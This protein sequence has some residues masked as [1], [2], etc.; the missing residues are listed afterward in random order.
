VPPP[1][2]PRPRDSSAPFFSVDA[3]LPGRLGRAGVIRTPH[4]DIHT[5]AFIA[6]GTQATVKAVLP[7]TMKELGAQA[8]LA[9]A[10]H[11]Y[12]QPGPDI[13][14]EAGGLGAF[15]NWH[16]PTFTDS[17]G[18][19]VLS[20]GA[21]FKKVLAMDTERVQ[22]DDVIAEGK[23]RLAH[24]DDDGVTFRSH[25]D[26]STHRFTPE[27]SIGIQHK[28]GADIIFA[29][30]ELTTLVN[31]RGYQE[32][33]VQRT[34][35]WAVRCLLEH[36]RLTALHPSKPAQ[37]LFGV[38]QGAQYEDL[39]RQATRGLVSIV[40]EDGRGFDGYGIG[41]A[42][43]K[44]NL[45]TIVGWVSSEL[46]ADKPRHLLGISEPD[47]LFDAVAAGAD[48]A[49]RPLQRHQRSVPARLQ[50]GRCRLR[51][52]HLRSLHPR[53]PAPP[54]QGERAAGQDAVHHPQRAL[55]HPAC[56]PDSRRDPHRRVRRTPRPRSGPVLLDACT[57]NR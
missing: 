56:R 42:L 37:A 29:F 20:L 26:G 6:V 8:V 43:E 30:D 33:S 46:P 7:E 54:V 13:V 55:R 41:G 53:I 17:G 1:N 10:Y 27:V 23:E 38:V 16:G 35:D 32:E 14:E 47:D 15:M 40:D 18:F 5:P 3:E 4:G 57:I 34:H 28:L 44:Q 51:L 36:R 50:P 45:A 31:T 48:T 12:L 9:N 11:L 52:L 21:G 22:A 2:S 39:R 19:Q 25:L 49:D 24:V